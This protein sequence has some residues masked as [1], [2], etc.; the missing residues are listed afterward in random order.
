MQHHSNALK[1][2]ATPADGDQGLSAIPLPAEA[3]ATLVRL[4]R[5]AESAV[6]RMRGQPARRV[7]R[8]RQRQRLEDC[9]GHLI[10]LLDAIDGDPDDEPEIDHG[11]DDE[12]QDDEHPDDEANGDEEPMLG[13]TAGESLSGQFA[14]TFDPDRE[15]DEVRP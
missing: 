14:R 6:L 11:I 4:R 12:P 15:L 7:V 13:W 9:I 5:E 10:A 8:E 1:R 3:L 2:A